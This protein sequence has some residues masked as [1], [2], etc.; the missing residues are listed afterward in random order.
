MR[1][2]CVQCATSNS[3]RDRISN[4]GRCKNCNHP[5]LFDPATITDK[6]LA[7][8]DPFFKKAIEDI[9]SQNMLFFTPKQFLYLMDKRLKNRPL[10][11]NRW[12]WINPYFIL[13][14]IMPM[15]S[16]I[17]I[18]ILFPQLMNYIHSVQPLLM[19]LIPLIVLIIYNLVW[20]RI[21]YANSNSTD[22]GIRG[23][24][25]NTKNLQ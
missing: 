12:G 4:S 23:R 22:R 17:F 1:M 19:P 20:I 16:F 10:S 7:F 2:K 6:K 3:L 14:A 21:F 25:N 18:G 13:L 15:F 8:T 5:F 11:A 9:S 24:K